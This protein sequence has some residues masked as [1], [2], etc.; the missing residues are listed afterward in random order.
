MTSRIFKGI[1]SL[2]EVECSGTSLKPEVTLLSLQMH[3]LSD[4]KAL[5]SLNVFLDTC[6]TLSRYS[7]CAI[8]NL[9]THNSRLRVLVDDLDQ[10]ER[11]GYGCTVNTFKSVGNPVALNWMIYIQSNSECGY[12]CEDCFFF[13]MLSS[14]RRI[15]FLLLCCCLLLIVLLSTLLCV[16]VSA[17]LWLCLCLY[18]LCVCFFIQYTLARKYQQT[19][20]SLQIVCL[21]LLVEG[22]QIVVALSSSREATCLACVYGRTRET[23]RV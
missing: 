7:S 5:A 23:Q 18:L 21:Q 22:K 20:T 4:K 10:G 15:V 9:N 11:R 13:A 6:V 8:D 2:Q 12:D 17:F 19:N 16:V 14:L 3:R 1:P